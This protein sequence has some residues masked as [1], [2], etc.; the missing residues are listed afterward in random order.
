M[1]GISIVVVVVLDVII[2]VVANVIVVV[3][4]VIDV[5][6]V[7][8]VLIVVRPEMQVIHTCR[9][10]SSRPIFCTALALWISV[11]PSEII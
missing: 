11:L 10:S 2:V 7:V 4:N 1:Q 6:V 3:V 9:L 8:T 5:A